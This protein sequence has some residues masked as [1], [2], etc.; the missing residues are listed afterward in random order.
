MYETVIGTKKL[1]V[2][3]CYS[4]LHNKIKVVEMT[5]DGKFHRFNWMNEVGQKKLM[6][7]LMKHYDGIMLGQQD[8]EPVSKYGCVY[9]NESMFGRV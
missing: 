7:Q 4:S 2:E 8:P 9:K 3:Y 6:S 1:V 5:A